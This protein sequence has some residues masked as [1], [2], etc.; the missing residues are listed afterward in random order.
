MTFETGSNDVKCIQIT[1]ISDNVRENQE[2]FFVDVVLN[3]MGRV[4]AG[5]P[6]RTVVVIEGMRIN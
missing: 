2:D 3:D 4:R 5:N 6:S 1:L